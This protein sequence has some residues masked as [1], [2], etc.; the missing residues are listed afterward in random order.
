L[1][2][3]AP[4][5]PVFLCAHHGRTSRAQ[6]SANQNRC[7]VRLGA[8][9]SMGVEHRKRRRLRRSGSRE[10]QHAVDVAED[11]AEFARV[12]TSRDADVGT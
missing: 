5:V 7:P 4:E 11:V 10:E 1:F 6:K 8:T 3:R 2:F 12:A 9:R